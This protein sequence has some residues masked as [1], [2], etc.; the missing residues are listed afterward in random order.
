[1]KDLLFYLCHYPF[2]PATGNQLKELLIR[3]EEWD[4]TVSLINEHGIIALAAYNIKEAGLSEMV[5]QRTMVLLEDGR[6]HNMVRNAWLAERWKEV[7]N[8]L[9]DSGIKHVLLKGMALEY[10]VYGGQGLRQMNDT[11]ILVKREE[12][13]KAW[14]LLQKHGFHSEMIKS[15]IYKKILTDIGKHLPSLTKDG[16]SVEIHHR[17]FNEADKNKTLDNAIDNA[18]EIKVEGITAYILQNEIHLDYL[19]KHLQQ[20]MLSGDFQLRLSA[21]ME[22]LKPGSAPAIPDSFFVKPKQ[23]PGL[24]QRKNVYRILFFS[25]PHRHRL[26][27]LA[28]DIFPSVRW[29]KKR[30]NC[31]SFAAIFYYPRRI[32]KVLWLIG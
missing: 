16:Y 1:M 13:L 19:K 27:Y 14:Y 20:H 9:S 18:V 7:N 6:R 30:H 23:L 15:P 21:D 32:A 22:L 4:K 12:A 10:A 8:I 26:R 28:G 5:P 17:L 11:D 25:V 3:V 24:K 31:S 29:L 2:D